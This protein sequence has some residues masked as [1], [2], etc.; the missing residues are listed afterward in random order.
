MVVTTTD[1]PPTTHHE[2]LPPNPTPLPP[3]KRKARGTSSAAS[4]SST[5]S[6]SDNI[7]EE[8]TVAHE[9]EEPPLATPERS[10]LS[11]T[12]DEDE[13]D[14]EPS[15]NPAVQTRNSTNST[16]LGATSNRNA[17][18]AASPPPRR[19]LPFSRPQ[20][21]RHA[22][23]ASTSPAKADQASGNN[24]EDGDETSDDEL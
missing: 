1:L 6:D 23:S 5:G 4:A 18:P 21:S 22:A 2:L 13:V 7:L 17:K 19:E 14:D 10:D 20:A 8:A 12:E 16:S 24:D 3:R 15:R 11:M 9:R